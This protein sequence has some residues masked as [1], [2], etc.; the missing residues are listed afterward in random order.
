MEPGRI[1]KHRVCVEE[2]LALFGERVRR[3]L[4]SHC[5]G[6]RVP[7]SGQYLRRRGGTVTQFVQ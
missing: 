3:R 2:L 4:I 7:T 5:G 6:R 1:S